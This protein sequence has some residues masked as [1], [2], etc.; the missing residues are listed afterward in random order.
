MRLFFHFIS[1]FLLFLYYVFVV[2]VQ[3]PVWSASYDVNKTINNH[4]TSFTPSWEKSNSPKPE[5]ILS[6]R[7]TWDESKAEQYLP[8]DT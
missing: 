8:S 2:K 5:P 1:F 7:S 4:T 3:E 6:P